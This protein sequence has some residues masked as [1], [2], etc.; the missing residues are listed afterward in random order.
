M[1]ENTQK[2]FFFQ[3]HNSTLPFDNAYSREFTRETYNHF[4]C[5]PEQRKTKRIYFYI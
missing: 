2:R 1:K 3:L 5:L 4:L